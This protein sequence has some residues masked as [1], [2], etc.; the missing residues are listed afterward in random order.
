MKKA[1][2]VDT[3]T[4]LPHVQSPWKVGAHVSAAGGVENAVENTAAIG[5]VSP[6]PF[7]LAIAFPLPS[8]HPSILPSFLPSFRPSLPCHPPLTTHNDICH[9]PNGKARHSPHPPYAS[10]K[11]VWRSMAT[12][13][14]HGNYLIN[15]GNPDAAKKAKSYECFVDD[16]RRC[17]ALGLNSTF[18]LLSSLRHSTNTHVGNTLVLSISGSTP[19][20]RLHAHGS[21]TLKYYNF[22]PGSTVGNATPE[23]SIQHIMD[24]LKAAHKEP[25]GIVMVLENMVRPLLIALGLPAEHCT[26]ISFHPPYAL[27]DTPLQPPCHIRPLMLYLCSPCTPFTLHNTPACTS[28]P[29]SRCARSP[30]YISYICSRSTPPHAYALLHLHSHARNH[31]VHVHPHSILPSGPWHPPPAHS[32]SSSTLHDDPRQAGAGNIISSSFAQIAAII[33]LVED[34]TQVGVCVDTCHAHPVGMM[35]VRARDGRIPVSPS[36]FSFGWLVVVFASWLCA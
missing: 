29:S 34:K 21:L 22:H 10:S 28:A 26:H 23:E 27:S 30:H 14:P 36:C 2:E 6:H 25:K 19:P 9:P 15:L 35:L 18:T 3:A 5:F 31:A 33:A 8:F 11:S 12:T 32:C 24:S 7:S 13:L 20:V 4:F 17:E 1:K 16:L